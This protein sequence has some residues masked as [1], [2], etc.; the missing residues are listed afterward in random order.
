MSELRAFGFLAICCVALLVAVP[1]ARAVVDGIPVP[2]TDR[3]FDAVGIFL[4]AAPGSGCGGWV[5]GT[6]TLVGPNV[7]LIARHCLDV[8][9]SEPLPAATLR[10]YRARFRRTPSGIS[11]NS[12]IVNGAQC[13]GTY[14]EFDV[15]QLVDAPNNGCDQVLAYLAAAPVGIVPISPAISNAPLHPTDIILAG[16]GST[17]ECFGA[18]G[19]W[20]LSSARGRLPDNWIANDYLVFSWCSIGTNAPCLNCPTIGGPFV[21]ANLH[22]SGAPILIEVPSTDPTDPTLELRLIGTVSSTNSGRRPSAWN[23][24]GGLP[25]LVEA[26]VVPHIHTGDF[27]GN[28]VR[29]V[30]DVL[31]YLSAFFGG[32]ADAD[33]DGSGT[34]EVADVLTYV[35]QWFR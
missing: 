32:R 10:Q 33:A 20:V 18:G 16:W 9:T 1:A 29:S 17:G 4:R 19:R 31:D 27:D 22:D 26:A 23:N 30:E 25:Q 7:V 13:H 6:C 2:A 35:D 15:I 3:R 12:L 24:S 21:T 8:S 34:V 28:G 11:E 5:T 14:Q